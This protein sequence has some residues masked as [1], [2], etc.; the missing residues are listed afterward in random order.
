MFAHLFSKNSWLVALV[1]AT[2]VT[3]SALAERGDHGGG[4]GG[5]R[6]GGGGGNHGGGGGGGG[7]SFSGGGGGGGGG[8]SS[9]RSHSGGGGGSMKSWSGGSQSG[10]AMRSYRSSGGDS[11]KSAWSGGGGGGGGGGNGGA[12]RARSFS[13]PAWSGGGGG[14]GGGGD[15]QRS[16][17]SR[18]MRS[19]SESNGGGNENSNNSAKQF[20]NFSGGNSSAQS[21]DAMR[22]YRAYRAQSGEGQNQNLSGSGAARQ[23]GGNDQ[24]QQMFKQYKDQQAAGGSGGQHL[25]R[26]RGRNWMNGDKQGGE[27]TAFDQLPGTSNDNR[28][29]NSNGGPGRGSWNRTG[30]GGDL[31]QAGDLNNLNRFR[32]GGGEGAKKWSGGDGSKQAFENQ[33]QR[34]RGGDF[35]GGGN[36]H[37]GPGQFGNWSKKDGGEF[38]PKTARWYGESGFGDHRGRGDHHDGDHDNKFADSVRKNWQNYWSN[39][40]GGHGG[41]GD[42]DDHD[43][44][45]GNHGNGHWNNDLPF[46]S[47]W[48][49]G[50]RNWGYHCYGNDRRWRDQ[51]FYWW[52]NCSAPLLTTWVDF[53]WNYPCYWDY[54]QGEYITYYNNAV[55]VDNQRYATELDYYA[56][57]RNLA[58]SVPT[59]NQNQLAAI[60]WLPLG[61]FAVTRPGQAKATELV[62]LAVSKDGI[63]SGTL[64]NQQ[65]GQA[66]PLQGRVE[67]AT[68]KAAWCFADS[69]T[70]ALVV[71]TSLYNLTE[72]ECTAL[73]HLDAVSTEVWQLVRLEQPPQPAGAQAPAGP[74]NAPAPA[75]QP[76]LPPQGAGLPPQETVLPPQGVQK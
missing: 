11:G 73:A 59:L 23:R 52:N 31:K 35:A 33:M 10:S 76:V 29:G 39:K 5:N 41:H 12:S 15:A 28:N 40:H 45:H 36:G 61:V 7:R 37:K 63:L 4:G 1:A 34:S 38:N 6:G 50:N 9:M 51:P 26:S 72:P 46:C 24:L 20:R 62:Q 44:H 16:F 53:G 75:V 32:N 47:S 58:R 60:E 68:Q 57:V 56:Q 3:G 25:D 42:H 48:W 55:Y 27:Q 69:P 14:G 21:G 70:D 49:G 2:L 22:Q 67:Q 66:R 54:G 8:S 71:E 19:Y 43:G 30:N 13:N 65:T 64:L 18:S 74:V 17:S